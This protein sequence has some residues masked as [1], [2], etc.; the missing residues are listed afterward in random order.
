M[1]GVG[2]GAGVGVEV[3]V[4]VAGGENGGT[5]AAHPVRQSARA[6]IAS[7]RILARSRIEEL[8]LLKG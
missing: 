5:M 4:G 7:R 3:G 8:P 1:E 6:A 2:V